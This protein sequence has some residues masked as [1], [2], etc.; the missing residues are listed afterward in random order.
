MKDKRNVAINS[1]VNGYYITFCLQ[2]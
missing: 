2:S 1:I